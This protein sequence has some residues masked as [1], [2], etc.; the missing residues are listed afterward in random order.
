MEDIGFHQE[1]LLRARRYYACGRALYNYRINPKGIMLSPEV[2]QYFMDVFYVQEASYRALKEEG[3]CEGLEAEYGLVFYV[4]GFVMPME[5]M[6]YGGDAFP[7]DPEKVSLMSNTLMD[8]FPDILHNPYVLSDHSEENIKMLGILRDT[9]KKHPNNKVRVDILLLSGG[10]GGFENVLRDTA[11]Y[12]GKFG[13]LVR[14]IQIVPSEIRWYPEEAEYV[15]LEQNPKNLDFDMASVA[16]AGQIAHTAVPDLILAAGWPYVVS[17]AEEAVANAGYAVPVCAWPHGDIRF[18]E[19]SGSGGMEHIL[20]ADLVFAI[21]NKIAEDI[22]REAPQKPVYRIKNSYDPDRVR[23][24]EERNTHKI[25]YVGRLSHEKAVAV[26]L[27]AMEAASETW[28]LYIAG[29]GDGENELRRLTKELGLSGRVHFSGWQE[30]PWKNLTDCRALVMTSLYEGAPLSVL[31]ALASGMQVISTPCGNVPELIEDGKTGFLY[32]F[33]NPEALA[34]VLKRMGRIPFT[35][36]TARECRESVKDYV[37]DKVMK[38]MAYKVI[39]SARRII[40][41]QQ[42]APGKTDLYFEDKKQD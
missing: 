19:E 28:E 25:A 32:P 18:Y 1:G 37:P 8:F 16:Y 6:I 38:D 9:A 13:C 10:H 24:S 11:L 26:I 40:L 30:D 27:Y 12:L 41:P 3:L 5:Y 39:A 15:C 14:F 17:V 29:S 34:D 42:F 35:P 33:A 7:Y 20:H 4:K 2:T 36:E 23:Y 31:E 22:Y 21:N